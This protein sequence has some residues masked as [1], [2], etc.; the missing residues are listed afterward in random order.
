MSVGST[1]GFSRGQGKA[2]ITDTASVLPSKVLRL[3]LV[4]VAA[5]SASIEGSGTAKRL[6]VTAGVSY[7]A[8]SL[9]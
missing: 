6:Q 8:Q 4:V 7:R 1:S 2:G 9:S 5:R 3:L